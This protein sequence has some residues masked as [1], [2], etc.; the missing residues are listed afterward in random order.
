[1][2][3]ATAKVCINATVPVTISAREATFG[4]LATPQ[5][6]QD[7]IYFALKNTKQGSNF[8]NVALTGYHTQSGTYNISTQF[9]MPDSMAKSV[10]SGSW[11]SKS[12]S[13]TSDP[14]VQVLTHGIGFDKTLVT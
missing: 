13:N 2:S 7:A 3:I 11:K 1:V 12:S 8:T 4:K 10:A 9:C 14:I 5:T 6:N